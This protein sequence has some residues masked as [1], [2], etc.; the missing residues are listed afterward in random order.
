M[1]PLRYLPEFSRM[2]FLRDRDSADDAQRVKA[3]A[4]SLAPA[5]IGAIVGGAL[6]P[7]FGISG[8]IGFFF[9]A[10]IAGAA[11]FV[12][13]TTVADRAGRAAATLYA[14][15]SHPMPSQFSLAESLIV[16]GHLDQA[17][18]ELR[19]AA[20]AEPDLAAPRIRLARLLRDRLRRPDEAL[21]WFRAALASRD[22]DDGA[23]LLLAH[24]VVDLCRASGSARRALPT[25]AKVAAE[26]P[27]THI[28]V[29]AQETMQVIRQETSQ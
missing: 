12:L 22:V 10:I 14:G 28:A 29:W 25:L 27:D 16:R 7:R 17:A 5:T 15:G 18:A 9:G 3:F 20:D 13:V 24:E 1:R 4:W 21:Q 11:S 26:R 19:R 6:A 8:L 2:K 23:A